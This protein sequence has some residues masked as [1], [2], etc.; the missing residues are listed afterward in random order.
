[1]RYN[2]EEYLRQFYEYGKYPKI[3]DEI[4]N[5]SKYVPAVSV[6]DLGCCY[7]LL[8]HRLSSVYKTVIGIE[9]E[10]KY[11]DKSVAGDNIVYVNMKICDSTLGDIAKI[12]EQYRVTGIFA[13][14]VI[15]EIYETGGFELCSQLIQ[16]FYRTG[17]EYI[18]IE[19]RK[20]TR[21]A[22]NPL[23]SITEESNIF[24]EKYTP[25]ERQANCEVLKRRR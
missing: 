20:S 14:R 16:T 15:P 19:G 12:I 6:M 3:H 4:F 5:L 23:K 2:D 24:S 9:S 10:K 21:R 1:M 22:V 17:I 8:S 13:R 25:I 7:G 18:A 11:L